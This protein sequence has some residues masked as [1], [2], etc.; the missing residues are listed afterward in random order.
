[1]NA[2]FP[3]CIA[4]AC[5][6]NWLL[7]Q[8]A[9]DPVWTRWVP[10]SSR[11]SRLALDQSA[12][13]LH[14]AF[15]PAPTDPHT[16]I[17]AFNLDGTDVPPPYTE[18]T[19]GSMAIGITGYPYQSDMPLRL[20]AQEDTLYYV[21]HFL[22]QIDYMSWYRSGSITLDSSVVFSMH[23][24][25]SP[26]V[27]IHHDQL[28]VINASPTLIRTFSNQRWL[29][30]RAIVPITD[31]IAANQTRIYCGRVPSIS[32][33]DR[34]SMS[35]LSPIGVPSSGTSTHTL[36]MLAGAVIHYASL[37]SNLTMD[38]GAVDITGTVIWNSTLS[39]AQYTSLSGIVVDGSSNTWVAASRSGTAPVGLLFRFS[40]TG[41]LTG[42]YTYGR[43][44]D[45]IVCSGYR[46]FL[47]GWDATQSTMVYLAAFDTD[48]TTS[49]HADAATRPRISPNPTS[50]EMR[51]EGL[52]QGTSR[53]SI[54]DVTGRELDEIRG[55][56]VGT[57]S[58][59]TDDLP[60]GTYL[61]RCDAAGLLTTQ[62]FSVVH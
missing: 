60:N 9:I 39:A 43:S 7:G 15:Q 25:E 3:F 33:L 4:T 14:L 59:S 55:P 22:Q 28:G 18:L 34:E 10:T 1:M 37:N 58:I 50:S 52:P 44:I 61:L 41:V 20:L 16:H 57:V 32:V 23:T 54:T 56:F 62:P 48:I 42:N 38:I 31:R 29:S 30:G 36:L 17:R 8:A 45:D 12:E 19:I 13:R 35:S 2:R 49:N 47:S 51:V 24:G 26:Q 21:D 11:I 5:A 46:I 6:A 27:D 53:V 40:S